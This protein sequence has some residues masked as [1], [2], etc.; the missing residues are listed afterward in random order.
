MSGII[1][2]IT[3]KS[4]RRAANDSIRAAEIVA[5]GERDKL[6]YIQEVEALPLELRNKFLP[7]YADIVQGGQGQQDLIN[8]AKAS[9]LYNAIMG[10]QQVGEDAILRNASMT[11]GLRSGN[12]Q[13]DLTDYGSQLQNTALLK[14]YNQQLQGIQGLA[15][16]PLNTN[17][18]AAAMPAAAATQGQGIIAGAQARQNSDQAVTNNLISLAGSFSDVRLKT[19]IKYI[20]NEFGHRVYTWAWN[21][22]A[23]KL[24]LHGA[25][26]GVMAHEVGKYMPDALSERDGYILVNYNMLTN[27]AE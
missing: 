18:V 23:G 11:G 10:G 27:G 12:V 14:S 24:G 16:M 13:G 1:D 22:L 25:G 4:G 5:G 17:S 7:Q 20:G 3:G 26:S 19:D 21:Q 9:P 8:S 6:D 2:T 15:N